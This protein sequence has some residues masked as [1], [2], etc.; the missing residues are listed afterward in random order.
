VKPCPTKKSK[1]VGILVET[2]TSWGRRIIQGISQY[3]KEHGAWNLFVEPRGMEE[4]LQLPSHWQGDGVIAR[5]CSTEMAARMGRLKIPVVNIS[6]IHIPKSKFPKVTTDDNMRARLA[7]EHFS[8]RG[9]HSFAYF[10]LRGLSYVTAQRDAFIQAAR[11]VGAGCPIYEVTPQHGAEPAWNT[12]VKKIGQWLKSLPLPTGIMTWNAGCGRSLIHAAKEVG[13]LIPE[14][15]AILSGTDDDLFCES[16]QPPLSAV[17]VDAVSIGY[18][19]AQTLD[20]KMRFG[21]ESPR[22]Q[23]VPPLRV[24]LR[25]SSDSLA[26]RDMSLAKSMIFIRA[27]AT[28]PIQVVEV[29]RFVGLSRRAL[30]RKFLHTLGRSPAEEIRRIRLERAK[31]LLQDTVID[32]PTVARNAGFSSPEYFAYYFKS[33]MRVTPLQ[34]RKKS[35][36]QQHPSKRPEATARRPKSNPIGG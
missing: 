36:L 20:Q 4:Q 7:I 1:A 14:K 3:S 26:I 23:L 33:Q 13:L 15:I 24:V 32:I 8:E 34:F 31:E 28:D 27:H 5:I 25:Q 29:S 11:K 35:F 6:G 17:L 30:E 19:A 2:S 9:F 10:S 16:T 18:Q 21:K 12:E 22:I